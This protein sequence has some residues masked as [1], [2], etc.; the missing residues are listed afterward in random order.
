MATC[1]VL[2]RSPSVQLA[3]GSSG[4]EEGVLMTEE[5]GVALAGVRR[6]LEAW[7]WS[8]FSGMTLWRSLPPCEADERIER[9]RQRDRARE[10]N[11]RYER[12][13]VAY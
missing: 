11:R 4:D 2:I 9:P 3:E 7:E 5:A 10:R 13:G 8:S 1:T 6:R 12:S